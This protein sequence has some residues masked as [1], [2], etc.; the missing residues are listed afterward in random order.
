MG[1][2]G[3]WYLSELANGIE[4]SRILSIA[5]QVK[6]MKAEGKLV[7]AFTFGDFSPEQF[8]V[9]QSFTDELSAAVKQNQTN[10]PPAAGLPE[11]RESLSN[12]MIYK[13]GLNVG[14]EGIIVGSGAR[15]VL[16]AS[17]KLFLEP[18]EG[19]AH[20]VPAW[21]NHYYVHLNSAIDIAIQGNSESRFLPTADDIRARISEIRVLI[22]N[23][24]L[25]PTGTCFT[26]NELGGICDVVLEENEKRRQAGKKPVM[27]VYDQV[28]STMTAKGIEHVHPVQVRPDMFEFTITLDAISKSLTATGLRLGWMALPP[29]LAGPVIALIGHMGSWPARPIQQAAAA[30]YSDPVK[31]ES[32]FE[33]L[34][35]RI[36][37]RME[38]LFQNL[39][40]MRAGGYP[41]D[42][43]PPQGGIYLSTRFNLF[44][45][46]GVTTN[47]EIRLWLLNEAGIAVIPFQAFGLEDESGWFRI[48]IGAVSV[49]E[50]S[51]SMIRLENA[52]KKIH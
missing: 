24:P 8:E 48:S 7:T 27:L 15:P 17:F 6:K 51:E 18:G 28:Y 52:L 20:G 10:Y 19:L 12:W 41:V 31:L 13:Y 16:F 22:L 35:S 45:V 25:N 36:S 37:D 42:F 11:L 2:D 39:S 3:E 5:T 1:S 14:S 46:L 23:S 9:P 50:V 40:N 34:D 47:E 32:Y 21:N 38:I 26:A 4:R 44:S 29:K 43:I 49:E 30:T 33:D